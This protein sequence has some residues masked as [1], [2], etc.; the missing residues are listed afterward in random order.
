ME[1]THFAG[2]DLGSSFTKGI[3]LDEDKQVLARSVE[4]TGINFSEVGK[5]ILGQMARTAGLTPEQISVV[6]T[7]IGRNNVE[8]IRFSKPEINCFGKGSYFLFGGPCTVV[9]IGGQDNKIIKLDKEGKQVFFRM[10]RKCAAGTG[11]FL[12]E[13]ALKLNMKTQD[14]NEMAQKA[15]EPVAVG[16]FCTVFAGTEI[17]HHLRAGENT[18]GLMRGVYESVTKRILE[19]ATLD[20]Q[21]ILT[22]G[23]IANN[24]VL[25]D[26]FR[27][28]IP[29]TIQVPDSPQ[30]V[31]A[32]GA[33]L[34]AIEDY[35]ENEG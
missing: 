4:R 35:E 12:E 8:G 13:I 26:L 32:L 18:D 29:N 20:D 34:Y 17:I 30:F 1:T 31:G 9:D 10:N 2:L 6:T 19:M 3:L 25:V 33:A 7:G 16:S 5:E 15:S 24:P 22:G 28:K 21:V 23:A 27:E 14:M 11:S